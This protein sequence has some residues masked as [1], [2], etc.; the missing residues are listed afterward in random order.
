MTSRPNSESKLISALINT[1]DASAA[2]V[3]GM[4]TEMFSTHGPE[5]RWVLDYPATY[6]CQPTKDAL[7]TRY[8]DFPFSDTANEVG[9]LCDD[10][11][12]RHT[13]KTMTIAAKGIM[14]SLRNGD[15]EEAYQY[16]ASVQHSARENH[17]QLRN[18]LHD[19]AFL[20]SY[21][22]PEERIEMPWKT[23]QRCT[24]GP[25]DGDFWVFAGRLG[26]GKSWVLMNVIQNA[27]MTG[28]N[29]L[30]FSLEMPE[31]QMRSRIHAMLARQLEFDATHQ[32][33]HKRTIS[34]SRYRK[35]LG[36]IRDHVLGELMIWDLS[37]G[38]VSTAHV[39]AM[40][41]EYD[42][43]V[44][45]HLGLLRTTAGKRAIDDW[46]EM[47]TI[48]NTMKEIAQI[49]AVPIIAAAQINR[50]GASKK[51]WKPPR[52]DQLSQSDAI[53][54]DADVVVTLR[55]RSASVLSY[56]IEKNRHGEEAYFHSNFQPNVGNLDEITK[57]KAD[58]IVDS[59]IARYEE[60]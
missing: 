59:E 56:S 39:S 42:V 23:L 58:A 38:P 22:D 55:Q 12:E 27:L 9:F 3:Y 45:D 8:P 24:G 1:G 40:S 33:L 18:V 6:S 10:V 30:L 48:S 17:Y 53:G 26:N 29:V 41:K 47:A 2:G 34:T 7:L 49:N 21:D 46:R 50:E 13:L 36:E 31:A 37:H 16:F 25:A 60:D 5:Y 57:T 14:E 15:S 52:V 19:E 11:K 54:Q 32:E 43:A 35:L 28:E 20:D 51:G 4:R 44:V